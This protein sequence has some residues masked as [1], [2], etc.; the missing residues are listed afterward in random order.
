MPVEMLTLTPARLWSIDSHW[1]SERPVAA[2]SSYH[3]H[4]LKGDVALPIYKPSNYR[5]LYIFNIFILI[6]VHSLT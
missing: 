1:I 5:E 6:K 3:L 4:Q 2:Y